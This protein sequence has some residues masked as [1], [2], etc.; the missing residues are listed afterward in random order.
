MVPLCKNC[1]TFEVLMRLDIH[2]FP[3]F[4][5]EKLQ[6]TIIPIEVIYPDWDNLSRFGDILSLL[7]TVRAVC[8]MKNES[9]TGKIVK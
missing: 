7:N 9:H 6:P 5:E 4:C 8:C 3:K 1:D 2:L